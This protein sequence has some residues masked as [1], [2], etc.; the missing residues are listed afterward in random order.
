MSQETLMVPPMFSPRR[1]LFIL[2]IVTI[3]AT[4]VLRGQAP[5]VPQTSNENPVLFGTG[6]N[7]DDAVSSKGSE[8]G[9]VKAQEKP[10]KNSTKKN[11]SKGEFA[12]AP[13]PVVNP[14]I[15]NGAGA[16]VLYAK[17]LGGPEDTSPA[18]AFGAGG[19]GTGN[20]SWAI[21]VGARTYFKNDRYRITTAF[22]GGKFN[23]NYFGEG[24]SAGNA[25]KSIPLSQ[26]AKAFLIEPKMRVYRDWYLGPRYH[27]ISNDV[28]LNDPELDPTQLPVPLPGDLQLRTAALGIRVQRD[29]S[30]SPYYP[31]T[32][33][34]FDTLVDFFGSGVGGQRN[35]QNVTISYSKYFSA[36]PKNVLAIRGSMCMTTEKAPFY[37]VCMLGIAK[38]LRG[39][40]IGQYRDDRMLVGQAE[41]RREL[42]W[43]VGA[44]AFAGAGAVAHDWGDFGNSDAQPGGGLG[45]RFVL[46]KRNHINL[47]V[48]YAWGNGS[49]ATYVSLAE[50][51]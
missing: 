44:V 21:G 48:D 27:I 23:Y 46:A 4:L 15:G 49:T 26:R 34:I 40:Q 10:A 24:N 8:L 47:R 50:A 7:V 35:Y 18:S 51:F 3:A 9:L 1:R 37:D 43:R 41:F 12:A 13:I 33:S 2:F 30:D 20:G 19:F 36:G 25:G 29:T 22:G 5:S 45:L 28:S 11:E 42:F 17:K 16:G 14:T 31:R 32:G 39:Y 38:D 6:T